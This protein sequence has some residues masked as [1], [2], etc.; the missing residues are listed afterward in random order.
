MGTDGSYR[1]GRC[2]TVS[3][4]AE[5]TAVL[6]AC[7]ALGAGAIAQELVPG[8]GAGAFL[9]RHRGEVRLRFA[10]RRLH[11]VPWSGGS[12][13]FRG[14]VRDPATPPAGGGRPGEIN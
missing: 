6:A 1:K 7:R 11:E 4:E 10:H 9:L 5:A 2:V 14:G 12:F 3:H 13:S 8:Y